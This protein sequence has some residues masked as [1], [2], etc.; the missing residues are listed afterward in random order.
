M[1]RGHVWHLCGGFS[2]FQGAM[3]TEQFACRGRLAWNVALLYSGPTPR[4]AAVLQKFCF[5]VVQMNL[6][7]DIFLVYIFPR[8]PGWPLPCEAMLGRCRHRSV[9]VQLSLL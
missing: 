3:S 6:Y 1:S 7:Y 5:S 4:C 9:A 2:F 8:L